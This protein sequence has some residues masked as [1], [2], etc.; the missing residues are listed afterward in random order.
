MRHYQLLPKLLLIAGLFLAG[1]SI[2]AQGI[3]LKGN[4]KS[5][6]DNITLPGAS[7]VEMDKTGRIITGAITD[8]FGNYMIKISNPENTITF[9]FI[10]YKSFETH[11]DGRQ[12][13][14]VSLEPESQRIQEVEVVGERKIND[15]FMSISE[16]NLTT[17]VQRL[18]AKEI[19]NIQATSIDEAMQGR[20]AG[21]DI[22]ASSGDPGAGMSIR[23]RGTSSINSSSE[24]LIVVDNI[25]YDTEISADFDFA[26]A[27]E[28]G[29]AAMLNISPEDIQEITVLK[30]AAST[31]Q[32]GSKAANG[33]LMIKTKRGSIGKPVV[34]YTY[35]FSLAEQP[36]PIPML[37]GD[38]YSMM[39]LEGFMNLK[40]VPISADNKEF[41]YD[42]EWEDYY[43]YSQNTDWIGAVTR[44]G[45]THDHNISLSGGGEKAR[46]RFSVGY[47]NQ[48][49]TTLG[50][51]LKKL[52]G[53]LNL[54]YFVSDKI[55]FST[56][57]SYNL[58]DNN[59]NYPDI[60]TK[61]Y[62]NAGIREIA[63]KKMP[64]MSIYEMDE[65][66]NPTGVYFSPEENSQGGWYTT[67]NPVAMAD[68]GM[69]NIL[70]NRVIPKFSL[71][72]SILTSLQYTFDVAFDINNE[73]RRSFLPQDATGKNWTDPNV[74]RSGDI[75]NDV[76][77]VQTFNK[78]YYHPKLGDKHD[79]MLLASFI[80]N[81]KT[82]YGYAVY[83]ANSASVALQDPSIES[84]IVN[85]SG[86]SISSGKSRSRDLA[87]LVTFSYNLLDRYI[88]SGS[89][90]RDGS[91]KFG[92]EH[93]WGT[94]PAISARW[95]IS[96][97]PFMKSL[98]FLDD[99]SIRASYGENGN[100]PGK[101]YT[102]Y[103]TYGTLSW[104]YMGEAAIYSK[105]MELA[106]KKWETAIQK[107]LG[108]ELIM[109][110][111]R[112]NIDVDFYH[113]RTLDL[114]F[115][116][117]TIPSSSGFNEIE[118]NAG[119]LD[120]NGWEINVI[121]RVLRI[122]ASRLTVDFN[123]NIA[124]NV[125]IIRE[126]SDLYPQEKGL[127][128]KNGEYLRR[129]Q[130]DNPV[131]SFYG[132]ILKG[133]YT[134]EEATIALGEDGK[135]IKDINGNPVY[136]TF[137]YPV[138]NYIF[139]AGDAMYEDINHDGNINELDVVYLGNAN[140]LLTGGFGPIIKFRGLSL[141]AFFHYR[142]GNDII[143]QVRMDTEKM[144]NYDN[145]STAVLRRWRNPGDMTDMPRALLNGGF[146]YLGSSRFVE[147]GSFVR[148]K[149]ISLNYDVPEKL[150][151]K[152]KFAGAR[153]GMTLKN[154]Y[155][156]TNYTGQDPEIS[157]KNSDLF[158]V[159]FDNSRT[160]RAKE[161]QFNISLSF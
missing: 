159:G 47:L 101:S 128:T 95:R 102:Q 41:R 108:F 32:W 71:R 133:V 75:D 137:N 160:P 88:L 121:S 13:I 5:S 80:T 132:Y 142:Y 97:E 66:G 38:Q 103:N 126:I 70:N 157:L 96:G 98:T 115:D 42:P 9:S 154:L 153:I 58:G 50:T 123:F 56:D 45:Y 120:N 111:D 73:K 12:T 143:N 30:D 78:L 149:Y 89:L 83:T 146:N 116:D 8:A 24:P 150:V 138:S 48:I 110:K 104:N 158:Y 90:R 3:L 113:K 144:Y 130:I 34:K 118:M 135:Q 100:A 84:R 62:K 54:D 44:T 72:Y 136:M 106:N 156:W 129:I 140:P 124:R 55:S 85:G 67:Y 2:F 91:S 147:D 33:V 40:G 87:G 141:N 25:P 148:L 57:I 82:N 68:K 145:Q 61:K 17:S 7:I 46:Y 125:N 76:F 14:N 20:L 52:S 11:L 107:D 23:I 74:N 28:E 21:V 49:G 112:I 18:D 139:Q 151:N 152:I 43:N 39:I 94:F 81:D 10:G 105:S 16:R 131:G 119:I 114:Y 161:F 15:G 117:L 26:T 60:D 53:R 27:D 31:A 35:K 6:D 134:D 51:D 99:L 22:V 93:R 79:L 77:S 122:D 64:N 29:Y 109:F 4:V 63:Y 36:D 65:E 127:A 86:L 19:E 1:N 59:K 69:Y 92:A 155:T 37:N